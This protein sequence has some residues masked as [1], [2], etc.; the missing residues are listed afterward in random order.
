MRGRWLNP[1][2]PAINGLLFHRRTDSSCFVFAEMKLLSGTL[3]VMGRNLKEWRRKSR[4]PQ[5]RRKNVN[6]KHDIEEQERKLKLLDF[7]SKEA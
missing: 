5:T 1:Q 2:P 3:L 7:P 6:Y 4:D